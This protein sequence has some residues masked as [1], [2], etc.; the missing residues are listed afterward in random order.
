MAVPEQTPINTYTANGVTTVFPYSFMILN[1]SDIR[2]AVD[3]VAIALGVDYT[4]S[5]V[6]LPTGGDVTILVAPANGL[7][8]SVYR[9]SAVERVT[10][11]QD[12]GDLLA[13]TVNR[14]YDRLWM[15]LQ[16][17]LA[18]LFGTIP[19]PGSAAALLGR[20]Q[21]AVNSSDGAGI[22]A[23]NPSL[24]YP[25][26]SVGSALGSLASGVAKRL[27]ADYGAVGNGV[28]DDT[29]AFTAAI[30]AVPEGGTLVLDGLFRITSTVTVN[31]RISL[32]CFGADNGVLLDI[33]SSADGLLYHSSSSSFGN[34]I[35]AVD[36]RLNVYGRANCCKHAVVF[37]RVDRSRIYLNVRAG[38]TAYGVRIR[39]CLINQWHIESTVNYSPPITSPGMQVSHVVVDTFGVPNLVKGACSISN[40]S[41]AVV[42]FTAHGLADGAPIVFTGVTPSGVTAGRVYY[43]RATGKTADAFTISDIPRAGVTD[44]PAINTTSSGTP[45][46]STATAYAS[47]CNNFWLNLEGAAD[48]YVQTT[49]AGEGANTISGE[50][51]GLSGNAVYVE[52]SLGFM[53]ENLKLEANTG[54]MYFRGCRNLTVGGGVVNQGTGGTLTLRSCRAYRVAGYYG[55]LDID[56]SNLGGELGPVEAPAI[57]SHTITDESAI[58]VAPFTID[59]VINYTD[60][61]VLIGPGNHAGENLFGNPFFDLWSTNGSG[62][63]PNGATASYIAART[64]GPRYP[65]NPNI[66]SVRVTTNSVA[67]NNGMTCSLAFNP[68]QED[69]YISVM[70]PVHV[71]AGQPGVA[72]FL[73]DGTNY[74]AILYD[75][76]TK[77]QWVVARGGCRLV[78]G[79]NFSVVL[80]SW[81]GSTYPSGAQ[82]FVGGLSVVFGPIPPKHLR[83]DGRRRAGVIGVTSNPPDFVGQVAKIGSGDLYMANDTA[84]SAAWLKISP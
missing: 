68:V 12:N 49:Q 80:A 28:A 20:L 6:G 45:T 82:F 7:E 15:V 26:G 71:A 79:G 51:E 54:V 81:N 30:A 59:P 64:I 67:I 38:A 42:S 36:I 84:S 2:V 13:D 53:A 31:R 25:A 76:T 72:V 56:S 57:D 10:D 65:G 18:G 48:G 3:G 69:G 60:P 23:F 4:V 61:N 50:I 70:V 62:G 11:Y 43:V 22:V 9:Q 35:N 44:G 52:E 8:V 47:N 63:P 32:Y 29:A 78:A 55:E 37:Q 39:G 34:G 41:P 16:E 58:Q 46:L 14:D 5:G 74:H 66:Y 73:Y 21:N 19:P 77:D 40:A 75:A 83:D 27:K 1:D 33:G 17:L 24:N